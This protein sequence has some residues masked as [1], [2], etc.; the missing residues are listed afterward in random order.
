MGEEAEEPPLDLETIEVFGVEDITDVGNGVPLFRDFGFE[1]FAL[2]SLR[3]ELHLLIHSFREDCNDEDRKGMHVDHV[4]FY[5]QKYYGKDLNLGSYGVNSMTDVVALV[6]D[7][8]IVKNKVLASL[9]PPTFES[10]VVF[11]KITEAARRFRLLQLD[12][13]EESARLKVRNPE[14][15]YK[16]EWRW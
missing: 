2:M 16:R 1:D 15:G 6:N 3:F 12:L 8:I 4:G 13:G 7:C 11:A 10:N 5:Y 14:Q 9:V